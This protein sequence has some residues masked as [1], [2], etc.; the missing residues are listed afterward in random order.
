MW[1]ALRNAYWQNIILYI[2]EN[3]SWM[4]WKFNYIDHHTAGM[5]FVQIQGDM[6]PIQ[7]S[8]PS[9]TIQLVGTHY[10]TGHFPI[11]EEKEGFF[12]LL[13]TSVFYGEHSAS[14]VQNSG[15]VHHLYDTDIAC[16]N[17]PLT[18]KFI[19]SWPWWYMYTCNKGSHIDVSTL[20]IDWTHN[21]YTPDH[22]KVMGYLLL[23]LNRIFI[24]PKVLAT[25]N[26]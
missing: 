23:V 13:F 16:I 4:F 7:F 24:F 22:S 12:D 1:C 14:S 26:L 17:F 20:H 2:K 25:D 5:T 21:R 3:Q 18:K 9:V 15:S 11:Y 10:M 6:I 8:L 19:V